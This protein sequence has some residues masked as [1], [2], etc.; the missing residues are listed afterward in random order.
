[1]STA[2]LRGQKSD[3]GEVE[4]RERGGRLSI[5]SE[6]ASMGAFRASF[7]KP[8]RSFGER[9]GLVLMWMIVVVRRP[10]RMT[11]HRERGSRR[12]SSTSELTLPEGS[13]R[14]FNDKTDLFANRFSCSLGCCPR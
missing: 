7:G 9:D 8:A 5:G 4:G 12:V 1:M 10:V 14:P 6:S 13:H 2:R 3:A 11:S